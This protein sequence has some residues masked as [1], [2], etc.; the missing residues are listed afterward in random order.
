MIDIWVLKAQ[1]WVNGR[2]GDKPGYNP[3]P[4]DGI[5]GWQTMYALTRALQYE[6]GIT[7]LSDNFGSGTTSSFVNKVGSISSST[8]NV[9]IVGILQ[10]ALWCKGFPGGA[11]LGEWSDTVAAAVAT[12]QGNIGVEANSRVNVKLMKSLLTMDAY[13]KTA[14]GSDLVREG[15]RWLNSKYISHSG[16]DILP[17]DGHFSRDVQ[18]GLM[19]AIQYELGI[20]DSVA[21]GNFGPS[22][23]S[24]LR[25]QAT[26]TLGASDGATRF[27]SLFQLALAFN[28]YNVARTGTFNAGTRAITLGFQDFM[29][30]SET[31]NGDYDT[32]AALLVSTGNP[33]RPVSMI[34]TIQTFT[35]AFA[36]QMR[37]AGYSIAGRYLTVTGKAIG[38]GELDVLFDAGFRVVPI[39]QNYNNAPE[40]FS[41]D[42]GY[43]HGA[44]A[45]MRARQLGFRHGVVIFFAV[46]YDAFDQEI[47]SLIKP[48]FEGVRDGLR[49]SH[50]IT[51]RIGIYATRNVAA[52]AV[53][54]GLAEAI[55]VS[56]MSTGYSGNLGF[57][58]PQGWW[59]NQIQE[60]HTLN[61]DR[62]AVSSRAEPA[63]RELVLR[64]PEQS[65]ASR[66][67]RWNIVR[68][69]VLAEIAIAQYPLV[70]ASLANDFLMFYLMRTKYAYGPFL[71]YARFPA[72]GLPV[73]T[74][75]Q[76]VLARG[77]YFE[78]AGLPSAIAPDYE[79]DL[80][81]LAV[82]AQGINYWGTVAGKATI[83]MGDLGGWALDAVQLWSNYYKHGG[84]GSITQFVAN[85]LGGGTEETSQWRQPDLIADADGWLVGRDVRDGTSF[86]DSMANWLREYPSWQT[87]L[88]LF[89]RARFTVP[90]MTLN[91]AIQNNIQ[92]TF[93]TSWPWPDYPRGRFLDGADD[94][95]PAQLTEFKKAC[96]DNLL[97][98]AGL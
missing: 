85:N 57:P 84:G 25:A 97:L 30:I 58:M 6:L 28:G 81:H 87:R 37:A 62:N 1:V 31:G 43:D 49:T 69:E 94:P 80:E 14:G 18:Q 77:M 59:Y 12:A 96:A 8:T 36:S 21:N 73:A 48:Y 95:T 66:Q 16:F 4:Q 74:A 45:A 60:V 41:Y 92:S 70:P 67:L 86:S 23:Q 72:L 52:R 46:D 11:D 76:W 33:D 50:S 20:A 64:T 75:D 65:A 63:T 17:C 40:Y 10:C 82:V 7:S 39:F 79:G 53:G 24:G 9:G 34:D 47:E 54:L 13:V 42:I 78:L 3:I 5:T 93:S 56:G 83:E 19:L 32:W 44:Q 51:Y 89:I 38:R 55:W 71:V 26:V 98:K 27:V 61:I 2:Y 29:E 90:G 35:P 88:E 68:Q 91:A 22:T 15:Q